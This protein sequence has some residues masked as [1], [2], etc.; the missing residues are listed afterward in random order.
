MPGRSSVRW[1]GGA[2]IFWIVGFGM[3]TPLRSAEARRGTPGPAG[4]RSGG[5]VG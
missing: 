2:D 4:G 3:A 5:F 1:A